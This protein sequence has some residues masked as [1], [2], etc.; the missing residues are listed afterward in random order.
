M[1]RELGQTLP[2]WRKSEIAERMWEK[3]AL[4]LSGKKVKAGAP[5]WMDYA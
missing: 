3:T 4:S 5:V 2:T 1:K